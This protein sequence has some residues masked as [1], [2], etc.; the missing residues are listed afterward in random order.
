MK[1]T[2]IFHWSYIQWEIHFHQHNFLS[3]FCS[4]FIGHLPF[5]FK[6][7]KGKVSFHRV[8][9]FQQQFQKLV[10]VQ[11]IDIVSVILVSELPHFPSKK[12]KRCVRIFPVLNCFFQSWVERSV[13]SKKWRK[14]I[15]NVFSSLDFPQNLSQ[16]INDSPKR[17]KRDGKIWSVFDWKNRNC[18]I[19]DTSWSML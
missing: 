17:W 15:P 7:P 16:L 2:G 19:N 12:R 6:Q 18:V 3:F 4:F 1:D 5:F 9:V 10:N 13:P 11:K 14:N 8:F